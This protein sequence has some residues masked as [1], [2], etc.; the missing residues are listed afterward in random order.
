M[1][2]MEGKNRCRCKHYH[3]E[4][5][6]ALEWEEGAQREWEG[7]QWVLVAEEHN[8]VEEL[9]LEWEEL[10]QALTWLQQELS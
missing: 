9:E 1:N 7:A 4:I 3:I 8:K 10:A 6:R 5:G 2:R